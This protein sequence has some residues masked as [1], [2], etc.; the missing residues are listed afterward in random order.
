LLKV[1]RAHGETA[2]IISAERIR[3]GGMG[4]FFAQE[5]VEVVVEVPDDAVNQPKGD[6]KRPQAKRGATSTRATASPM[7]PPT[8]PPAAESGDDEPIVAS[9]ATCTGSDGA[10]ERPM[11]IED[12]ADTVSTVERVVAAMPEPSQ[13]SNDSIA[14]S[15]KADQAA[16]AVIDD[17]FDLDSFEAVL[18]R[19]ASA[20]TAMFGE[21]EARGVVDR[22]R[23]RVLD[24]QEQ[25]PPSASSTRDAETPSGDP[26]ASGDKNGESAHNDEPAQL[27]APNQVVRTPKFSSTATPRPTDL[28]LSPPP[29]ATRSVIDATSTPAAPAPT[30]SAAGRPDTLA[31]IRNDAP[32][33]RPSERM[34]AV[35]HDSTHLDIAT[36]AAAHVALARMG[37]PAEILQRIDPRV[38]LYPQL[39]ESFRSLP[40]PNPFPT[41][42]GSVVAVIGWRRAAISTARDLCS[43]LGL[44]EENV[45][46]ACSRNPDLDFSE[47]R[48]LTNTI[49]AAAQRRSW[50]RNDEPTVIAI[51]AA[52]GSRDIRWAE[53]M[54]QALSPTDV[55]GT[56]DAT[57]KTEDVQDWID[58]VGSVDCL[59]LVGASLTRTPAA[60]LQLGIPVVLLDG[61]P[62]T[63]ERW[64]GLLTG[65]L[66][67]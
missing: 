10:D 18:D 14:G 30:A 12:L 2:V 56:V 40:R 54:L 62:A 35:R 29:R 63:A 61:E 16:A 58:G 15:A 60:T 57:R 1:Q 55:W 9:R 45:W 67:A 27:K 5:R 47:D 34:P 52:L 24:N 46:F 22:Q 65:R 3:S 41:A 38:D 7:K 17:A 33:A 21:A 59:T 25:L 32:V 50:R 44:S 51:D 26:T 20:G 43:Q 6:T 23:S 19:I 64:A 53:Q 28:N 13:P 4:G 37:V 31:P 49:D 39:V 66:A 11:S 8:A 48:V 42:R 36:G